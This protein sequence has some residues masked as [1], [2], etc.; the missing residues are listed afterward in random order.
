MNRLLSHTYQYV[1]MYTCLRAMALRSLR[2][3]KG[4]KQKR[5]LGLELTRELELDLRAYCEAMDDA[6]KAT[7]L[8]KALNCYIQSQLAIN[9][10]IRSSYETIRQALREKEAAKAMPRHPFDTVKRREDSA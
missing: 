9:E 7:V 10:G 2:V 4:G 3:D 8:R 6:P 1:L 5:V